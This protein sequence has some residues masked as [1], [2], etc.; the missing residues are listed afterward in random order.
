[1]SSTIVT[2]AVELK[3]SKPE[4]FSDARTPS[5]ESARIVKVVSL[6]RSIVST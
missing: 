3:A 5:A 1:M 2:I 6:V 4:Y